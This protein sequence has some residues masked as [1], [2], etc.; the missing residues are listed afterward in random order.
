MSRSNAGFPGARG[1][2][3]PLPA[4]HGFPGSPLLRQALLLRWLQPHHLATPSL[5]KRRAALEK[6]MTSPA[7]V[8]HGGLSQGNEICSLASAWPVCS[9]W[10]GGRSPTPATWTQRGRV[11]TLPQ[12]TEKAL[13]PHRTRL[14]SGF[15]RCWCRPASERD[16]IHGSGKE[17]VPTPDQGLWL[18]AGGTGVSTMAKGKGQ[19]G[20]RQPLSLPRPYP[21]NLHL[22]FLH[23]VP[24]AFPPR[25][26]AG[27]SA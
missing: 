27:H 3:S 22:Q 7:G 14:R 11:R 10:V 16:I 9:P 18:E 19:G 5:A 15:S 4:G 8:S 24:G 23:L 21:A 2:G 17:R 26:A 12:A 13:P 20:L 1:R 6:R 25:T